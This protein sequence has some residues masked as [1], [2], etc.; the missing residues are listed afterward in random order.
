MQDG[1]FDIGAFKAKMQDAPPEQL[2]ELAAWATSQV[3][4][5]SQTHRDE[6]VKKLDPTAQRLFERQPA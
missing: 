2:I 6:F 3:G 4:R 5:L 1:E